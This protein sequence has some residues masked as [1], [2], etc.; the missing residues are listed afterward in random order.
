MRMFFFIYAV[1]VFSFVSIAQVPND[2]YLEIVDYE[3]LLTLFNVYDGDTL[4]QERVIGAY[5][6]RAKKDND[7]IKIARSYDRMARIYSSRKNILYADSLITYTRDWQH[8]TYPALGYII[9]GYEYGNMN[10]IKN[11]NTSFYQAFDLAKINKNYSQQLYLLDMLIYL[12]TTWGDAT[13]ALKLQDY[14]HGLLKKDSIFIFLKNSTRESLHD[15]I[16]SVYKSNLLESYKCYAHSYLKLKKYEVAQSYVD[17]ISEL[18]VEMNFP[19]EIDEQKI[20]VED[21]RN[22]IDFYLGD[23]ESIDNRFE[24]IIDFEKLDHHPKMKAN[25][26][27][28]RGLA[29][30]KRDDYNLAL[31]YLLTAL[32]EKKYL[33]NYMFDEYDRLLYNGLFEIYSSLGNYSQSLIYVDKLLILDSLSMANFK[34]LEPS[35]IN[36]FE[37]PRLIK[38]KEEIIKTLERRNSQSV[39]VIGVSIVLFVF[40]SALSFYYFRQKVTYRR[41]FEKLMKQEG[42]KE[43][44]T[45]GKS[46]ANESTAIIAE[47]IVAD[48]LKRL[49]RFE[50]NE[51]FLRDNVTLMTLAK[52]MHTN[53]SYLSR[54]V[55]HHK[56]KSFSQY[57]NDLRIDYAVLK[58]K[59]DSVFRRYTV[60]AIASECGY[61]TAASFSRSFYKKTGI[62]PS[63]MIAEISKQEEGKVHQA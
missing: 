17:T 47:D 33:N 39:I 52:K 10:D 42:G 57:L 44:N 3:E 49:N 58:I 18:I 14:R 48:I 13:N 62:Y 37:T 32:N 15:Q 53:S 16:E 24:E 28:F 26:Y 40:V 61:N 51:E 19:L 23:Y 31:D 12:R 45:S 5:L 63:F 41:R 25:I 50:T 7:T 21:A 59:T 20:W 34:Y 46:S 29:A 6:D 60:E 8:I 43:T 9:K 54:V 38:S 55:N 35:Y 4:V 2:K 22:E 1:L 56:M 27:L 30:I 11:Q 36:V